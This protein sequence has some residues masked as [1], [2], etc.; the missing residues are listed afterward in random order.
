VG[1]VLIWTV[2]ATGDCSVW[3]SRQA[4]QC[5]LFP[6]ESEWLCRNSL[7]LKTVKRAKRSNAVNILCLAIKTRYKLIRINSNVND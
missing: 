6:L 5:S 4:E 7:Q 3:Q 2:F 1:S